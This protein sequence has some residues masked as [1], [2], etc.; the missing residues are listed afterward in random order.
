[1][2]KI[3]LYIG[4]SVFIYGM[5]ACD[6]DNLIP[7]TRPEFGYSVPQG[8]HDYD[9]R[10]VDWK[11]RCNFFILYEY[12]PR[13][14]YWSVSGWNE[15]YDKGTSDGGATW[16]AGIKATEADQN[17]VGQQLDLLENKFLRFYQDTMLRRCMPLKLLLCS[18]LYNVKNAGTHTLA[19]VVN[20]FDYLAVNWGAE[21]ILSMTATQQNQFRVDINNT[22]LIRLIDNSKTVQTPEF[23][24]GTN[25]TDNVTNQNMYERGFVKA[26]KNQKDDWPNYINAII[27]TP[28]SDLIAKPQANDY[29]SKG[30]LHSDKDKNG[31]IRKK[32]DIIIEHY[33]TN[34]K[35]DLQAIGDA[36]IT[37]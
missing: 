10:I 27:S 29:T 1:M 6:D 19:N 30:I 20:G 14:I 8:E 26:S 32:Y 13:D 31:L 16:Q 33:K 34:Y 7:T 28:Y 23:Y 37:Q 25:Y 35:V 22:F 15:A 21:S 2:K 4:L 12:Q 36:K 5:I 9:D 17:Y 11:N 3:M 24:K 18:E